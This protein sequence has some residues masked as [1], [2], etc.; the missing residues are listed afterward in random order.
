MAE[1]L[2]S[3]K[4][5]GLNEVK[6]LDKAVDDLEVSTK[7]SNASLVGW[8]AGLTATAYAF[9][10]V[11][12]AGHEYLTNMEDIQNVIVTTTELETSLSTSFGMMSASILEQTGLWD[13]YRESLVM[14]SNALDVIAGKEAIIRQAKAES[15]SMEKEYQ[16]MLKE[17]AKWKEAE[18]KKELARLKRESDA[19][20]RHQKLLS[21]FEAK[22]RSERESTAKAKHDA[23]EAE[24]QALD[25]WIDAT[26]AAIDKEIEHS[27]AIQENTGYV[28][29]NTR[30]T[31]GNTSA[32]DNNT[33]VKETFSSSAPMIS[34]AES[35]ATHAMGYN[36][37]MP[38]ND[39]YLRQIAESS[40]D[41]NDYVRGY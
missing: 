24:L 17:N 7:R 31:D 13:A 10:K 40:R 25:A 3:A 34:G 6:Q 27:Q 32:T 8:T 2:I 9:S 29:D 41:T 35:Y 1:L 12:E 36:M 38:T 26:N 14:A 33:K 20:V 19:N 11:A 30:A 21:A 16:E 4:V 22:A 39:R 37:S 28:D 18:S 15:I 5:E 23:Y